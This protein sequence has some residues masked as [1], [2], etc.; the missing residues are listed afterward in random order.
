MCLAG[1]EGVLRLN[2]IEL[3]KSVTVGA[4]STYVGELTIIPDSFPLL[5][6]L[7]VSFERVKWLALEFFWKPAVGTTEG[8]L[9]T[10]GIDW[11]RESVTASSRADIA[12]YAPSHTNAIWADTAS[13]PMVLPQSRLMSRAYYTPRSSDNTEQG[14]G[15]LVVFVDGPANKIVGE[16]WARY[17]VELSG[18]RKK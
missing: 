6:S 4:R 1:Q 10:Y 18:T 11:D 14:P 5:S 8:G 9:V 16:L 12:L 7:F 17:S 13:Q 15:S 3:V 2:K